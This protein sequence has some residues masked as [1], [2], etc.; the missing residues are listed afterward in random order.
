MRMLI[1]SNSE[2]PGLLVMHPSCVSVTYFFLYNSFLKAH[3]SYS[4]LFVLNSKKSQ[5]EHGVQY[6]FMVLVYIYDAQLVASTTFVSHGLCRHSL[7]NFAV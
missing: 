1:G 7:Y 5:R 2:Q 4:L 3:K 6:E